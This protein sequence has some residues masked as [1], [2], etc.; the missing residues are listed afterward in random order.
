MIQ[1][2]SGTQINVLGETN[3]NVK[4]CGV[5]F[6]HKFIVVNSNVNLLGRDVARK[7]KMSFV[8]NCDDGNNSVNNIFILSKFNKY[9]SDDFQS[10]IM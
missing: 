7:L 3:L 10:C 4:C 9:L 2:Y 6:V 1:G 5:K 8:I